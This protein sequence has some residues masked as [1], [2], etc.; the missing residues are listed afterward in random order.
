ME[1]IRSVFLRGTCP[2]VLLLDETLAPLDPASK[3]LVQKLIKSTCRNSLV[4]VIY[5]RDSDDNDDDVDGGEGGGASAQA[6]AL[7][8][9]GN[10]SSSGRGDEGGWGKVPCVPKQGFF[11]ASKCF[12]QFLV[13]FWLCCFFQKCACVEGDCV[14]VELHVAHYFS[15]AYT[16]THT[17]V[18]A[19]THTHIHTH[20]QVSISTATA[21]W[22]SSMF[23]MP[24]KSILK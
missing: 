24:N 20:I 14:W 10:G 19:H 9:V 17:R 13:F 4:L 2:K 7:D 23:A 5:H 8:D 16:H 11:S 18:R 22:R 3:G 15:H 1:L 12:S 6:A 21:Q